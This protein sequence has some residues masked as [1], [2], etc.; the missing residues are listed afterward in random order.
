MWTF[1]ADPISMGGDNFFRVFF[2]IRPPKAN[3][4]KILDGLIFFFLKP[5]NRAPQGINSQIM[6]IRKK[7]KEKEKRS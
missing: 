5:F 3:A 6:P 4:E 1:F 2:C 7:K